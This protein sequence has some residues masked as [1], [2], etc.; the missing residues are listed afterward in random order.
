MANIVRSAGCSLEI[1]DAPASEV[2]G[3]V[4]RRTAAANVGDWLIRRARM[5][6][7]RVDDIR[8]PDG[9]IHNRGLDYFLNRVEDSLAGYANAIGGTV[10]PHRWKLVCTD[11]EEPFSP[12][13]QMM[14]Q[15]FGIKGLLLGVEV[16]V[17]PGKKMMMNKDREEYDRLY[18]LLQ[19]ESEEQFKVA[20]WTIP[21][22]SVP[23]QC[24]NINAGTQNPP[25]YVIHDIEPK[26]V[27]VADKFV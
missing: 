3:S 22:L 8:Y 20:G 6:V 23:S 4:K 15:L 7:A 18:G 26:T 19:I 1:S 16:Q 21:D 27:A 13:H 12:R 5:D 25:Q 17:I 11:P 14:E 24:M 9:Q 2:Y 10:V